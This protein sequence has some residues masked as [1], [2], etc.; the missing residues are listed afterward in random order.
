MI[1]RIALA[2]ALTLTTSVGVAACN[3][4]PAC[5][6]TTLAPSRSHHHH[7]SHSSHSS[8]ITHSHTLHNSGSC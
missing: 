3:N 8:G 7:S 1:R 4:S 6:A 2:V 5:A